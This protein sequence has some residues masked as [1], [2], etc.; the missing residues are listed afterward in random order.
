MACEVNST[1]PA[2]EIQTERPGSRSIMG[3]QLESDD[4]R[5]K[6]TQT[7]RRVS[8]PALGQPSLI[9]PR[10][11]VAVMTMIGSRRA[12]RRLLFAVETVAV[13]QR[14]RRPRIMSYGA[15]EHRTAGVLDD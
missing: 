12:G 4:K 15:S 1:L 9:V 8:A 3:T 11:M 6:E 13:R 5:R 10:S 14:R 7:S 2:L